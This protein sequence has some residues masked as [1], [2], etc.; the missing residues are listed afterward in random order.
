MNQ[1]PHFIFPIAG[2][3]LTTMTRILLL[4]FNHSEV[5]QRVHQ[6]IRSTEN[7]SISIYQMNYIRKCIMETLRLMNPLITTFRS[8]SEDYTFDENYSFT[9]GTQFLILN[10]PVLREEFFH[11]P[12]KFIPERWTPELEKSYYAIS[13]NQ[14]PQRCPSKELV[15]FLCQSFLYHLFTSKE[16]KENTHI[17]INKIN[18]D[19]IPQIT[20]P[21]KIQL[22]II[23]QIIK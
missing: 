21:F 10:N 16:I 9:K 3:F 1:I 2:L 8:L 12:N 20:N 11:E 4:V 17:K 18:T 14:G 5:L 15:I 7:N 22:Q 19:N 23:S 6:E 13:F